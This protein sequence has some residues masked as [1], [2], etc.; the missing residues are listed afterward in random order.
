MIQPAPS[1]PLTVAVLADIHGN[2]AALR[3]VLA[4]LATQSYDQLVIAGD[5]S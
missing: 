1:K 3:A 4:D 5:L 2:L